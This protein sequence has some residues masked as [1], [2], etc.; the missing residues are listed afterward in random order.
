MNHIA[1]P[2]TTHLA[3]AILSIIACAAH[4]A[5]GEGG[6][7]KIDDTTIAGEIV[8]FDGSSL[9]IETKASTGPA[10]MQKIPV[11]DLL[12]VRMAGGAPTTAPATQPGAGAAATSDGASPQQ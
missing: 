5:R 2:I 4:P 10:T 6:A 11:E 12:Q 8:A 1:S 7:Q 9:T 3:L